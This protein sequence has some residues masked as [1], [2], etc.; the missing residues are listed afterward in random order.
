MVV[1]VT[2]SLLFAVEN[3]RLRLRGQACRKAFNN[4]KGTAC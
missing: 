1:K 2:A 4:S 3:A